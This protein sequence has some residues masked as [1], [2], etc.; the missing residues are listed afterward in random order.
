TEIQKGRLFCWLEYTIHPFW[1]I[2]PLKA[3]FLSIHP[4]EIV[5]YHKIF[6]DSCV[7]NLKELA[8]SQL[9][10]STTVLDDDETV[11]SEDVTTRLSSTVWMPDDSSKA[12]K[13]VSEIIETITGL[14]V[15]G[16][17]AEELQITAY[18]PG[19]HYALHLDSAGF[20]ENAPVNRVA[21]FMIYDF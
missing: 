7:E 12:T 6:S 15:K 8:S 5:Q 11:N 20:D 19:G 16:N 10:P 18:T 2:G 1:R 13:H 14:K 17:A 21:T 3:E 9:L 4:V